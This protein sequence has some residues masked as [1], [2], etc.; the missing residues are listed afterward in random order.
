M[1]EIKKKV[2]VVDVRH[3]R[4]NAL[5]IVFVWLRTKKDTDTR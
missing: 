5:R 3:V 4:R 1:I 2:N